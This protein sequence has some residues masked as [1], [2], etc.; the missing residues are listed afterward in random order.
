MAPTLYLSPDSA[1][2]LDHL[3]SRIHAFKREDALQP[4]RVL[5]STSE[6]VRYVRGKM[7][8][9]LNVHL[10]QFYALA[11]ELLDRAAVP[12]TRIRGPAGR[13]S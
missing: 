8:P 7:P 4:V 1:A 13:C 12:V 9:I 11:E 5:L 6:A 2:S 10:L 3:L